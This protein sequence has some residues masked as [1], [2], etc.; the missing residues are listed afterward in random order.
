MTVVMAQF[1]VQQ[2]YKHGISMK[3][4]YFTQEWFHMP[5]IICGVFNENQISLVMKVLLK[6]PATKFTAKHSI[7]AI[8]L[9]KFY[10]TI[11]LRRSYQEMREE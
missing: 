8:K 6:M 4:L 7:S 9:Y 3:K 5:S 10:F 2:F 11:L 1:K